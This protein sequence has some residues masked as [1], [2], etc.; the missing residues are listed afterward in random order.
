MGCSSCG[1]PKESNKVRITSTYVPTGGKT[2]MTDVIMN[3]TI[4]LNKNVSNGEN[5]ED[6]KQS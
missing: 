6:S 1:K 3:Y 5:K 2:K 4:E